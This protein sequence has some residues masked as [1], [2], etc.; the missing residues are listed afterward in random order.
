MVLRVIKYQKVV[1]E[2]EGASAEN[3]EE[4]L[5]EEVGK[6]FQYFGN[7]G[8][9]AISITSGTLKVGDTIRIK[10]ATTDFSQQV[11]SMEIDRQKVDNASAGQEIG[12][13][14]KDRVRPHDVVYRV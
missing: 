1:L 8:V 10:G 6:V 9:A 13:K 2:M 3:T 12:I 11:E 5:G 14:V 4:T 7:V